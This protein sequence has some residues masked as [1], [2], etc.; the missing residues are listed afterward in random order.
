MYK[1]KSNNVS[2]IFLKLFE[3]PCHAYPTNFSLRNFSVL[4]TFL[5]TTRFAVSARDPLLWNNCLSKNE[6][7]IDNFYCS[8]KVLKKEWN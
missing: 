2:H 8:K 4:Q 7:G 6:K 3:V 5:K 1:I